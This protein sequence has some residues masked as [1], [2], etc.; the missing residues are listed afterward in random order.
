MLGDGFFKAVFLFGCVFE[1]T[2]GLRKGLGGKIDPGAGFEA[3]LCEDRIV[4]GA[5]FFA[6]FLIGLRLH[7]GRESVCLQALDEFVA[8]VR[9]MRGCIR[10]G[11]SL[12]NPEVGPACGEV[13]FAI[14][15]AVWI[16]SDFS[17]LVLRRVALQ[18]DAAQGCEAGG[19]FGGA[20]EQ[21]FNRPCI[22]CGLEGKLHLGMSGMHIGDHGFLEISTGFIAHEECA[23][24]GFGQSALAGFIGAADKVA[25]GIEIDG[26]FAVNAIISNSEGNKAHRKIYWVG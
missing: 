1:L 20:G 24:D 23:V 8:M 6:G 10:A 25:R 21:L 11:C 9:R 3:V 16:G 15:H 26:D 4:D 22:P 19:A 12:P 13:V 18:A 14:C 7:D 17:E 2:L 5:Y